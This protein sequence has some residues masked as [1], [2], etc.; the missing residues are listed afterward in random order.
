[1]NIYTDPF[2]YALVLTD[3]G[4]HQLTL[5]VTLCNLGLSLSLLY[6]Y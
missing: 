4:K 3:T 2:F 1:M 6:Y 5:T